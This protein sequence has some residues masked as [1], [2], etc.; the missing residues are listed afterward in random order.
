M[1]YKKININ[2]FELNPF[3]EIGD[4]WILISAKKEEQVNTMTASWGGLGL[5]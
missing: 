4:N 2:E 3:K 1:S 5:L